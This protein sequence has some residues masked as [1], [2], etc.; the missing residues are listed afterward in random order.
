M[1]PASFKKYFIALILFFALVKIIAFYFLELG[2]DE[3]YYWL[4]MQQLQ[5]NYFDHPPMVAL[6]GR[7]FSFNLLLQNNIIFLRLGSVLASALAAFCIYKTVAL[8]KDSR[9][10][11]FAACL[12]SSS[13]YAGIT[14][15]I[16][17]MPDAPQMLFY[18]FA[19]WMLTAILKDETKWKYWLLFGAAAG[20]CIMSK[21]H[22]VFLWTGF[23]LY[24]LFKNRSWLINPKLYVAVLI[25]FI[26][27]SPILIWNIRYDFM[28]YRFH[29]ERVVL[30]GHH[31][32]WYNLFEAF[33]GQLVI[34]NPINVI[35]SIAGLFLLARKKQV[36]P[37]LVLFNFIAIP[38]ILL[39]LFMAFF[40]TTLPHWSG[41]AFVAL[42]PIAA[43]W[44]A[45]VKSNII[46]PAAIKM[47]IGTY[48]AGLTTLFVTG[49]FL[50][51]KY[52]K[53]GAKKFGPGR[54]NAGQLWLEKS[55]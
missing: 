22:G 53:Q 45:G 50:P 54:Y 36:H 26:I 46:F 33:A 9:A 3:S 39:I 47:S 52:G 34:N 18:T 14:A 17:L 7:I 11:W 28:T 20:F 43:V 42:I 35:L 51:C 5:W 29:S 44:L 32:N 31:S 55:R 19:L 38:F 4:Y 30:A 25:T 27:V 41:P 24:V 10:G 1:K 23:G 21:I 37:P 16:F 13:F 12:Y 2:N 40:R 6:W 15:G 49:K 48:L 8:I